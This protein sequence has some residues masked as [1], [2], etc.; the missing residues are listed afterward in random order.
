[1][2]SIAPAPARKLRRIR[3]SSR[4]WTSSI[5]PRSPRSARRRARRRRCRGRTGPRTGA[6]S[7]PRSSGCRAASGHVAVR[8]RDRRLAQVAQDGADD[9]DLAA[10]QPGAHHQRVE[11]VVLQL[12]R[13]HAEERRRT[14]SRRAPAPPGRSVARSRRP[15]PGLTPAGLI[16][17]GRSSTTLAPMCSNV[18]TTSDSDTRVALSSWQRTGSRLGGAAVDGDDRVSGGVSSSIRAMS[19]SPIGAAVGPVAGRERIAEARV[20]LHLR[21]ARRA[22]RSAPRAARR[23]RS[24]STRR[25]AP[26]SPTRR[27]S[28]TPSGQRTM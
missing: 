25:S 21:A 20:Q 27:V 18:G 11:P 4:L 9:R 2:R 22:R 7:P 13:P 10:G 19:A 28:G 16:S 3:S 14:R 26:R 17:Y 5:S 8:E 23:P 24:A 12:A 6:P 15:R 1:M